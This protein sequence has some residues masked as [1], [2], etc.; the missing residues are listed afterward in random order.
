MQVFGQKDSRT[1]GGKLVSGTGTVLHWR[2]STVCL[3]KA[4]SWGGTICLI[5]SWSHI[6]DQRTV[7]L[8]QDLP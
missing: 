1:D 7:S 2:I 4:H 3:P 6:L 8:F 5:S